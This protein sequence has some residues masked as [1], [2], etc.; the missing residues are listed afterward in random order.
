MNRVKKY[1]VEKLFIRSGNNHTIKIAYDLKDRH[2][3]IE[4]EKGLAAFRFYERD[5]ITD[6][7]GRRSYSERY[8]YSIWIVMDQYYYDHDKNQ[9]SYSEYLVRNENDRLNS[10]INLESKVYK[11]K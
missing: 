9:M 3:T 10:S 5:L 4:N 11:K 7:Y 8:N 6:N 2:E 1:Y